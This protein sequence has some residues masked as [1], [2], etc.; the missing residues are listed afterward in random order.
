[1]GAAVLR[2]NDQTAG[3]WDLS[4]VEGRMQ[5]DKTQIDAVRRYQRSVNGMPAP[6]PD[7][8]DTLLRDVATGRY[9][10]ARM[11]ATSTALGLYEPTGGL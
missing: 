5:R 10:R 3:D 11:G 6:E 1:M 7:V 2:T 4:T 9:R 8:A